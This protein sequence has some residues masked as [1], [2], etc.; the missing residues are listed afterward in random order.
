MNK[1]Q[2]ISPETN[3]LFFNADVVILSGSAQGDTPTPPG[4][5]P[6]IPGMGGGGGGGE[7]TPWIEEG[8]APDFFDMDD[9]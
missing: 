6:E 5:D 8:Y 4:P 1:K 9:F 3:V 2:Y 7:E